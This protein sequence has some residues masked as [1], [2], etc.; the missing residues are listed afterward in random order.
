MREFKVE[1][2]KL[3][4][5]RR[6]IRGV[7]RKVVLP[8]ASAEAQESNLS[9]LEVII[10]PDCGVVYVVAGGILLQK[11]AAE[12]MLVNRSNHGVKSNQEVHFDFCL[13]TN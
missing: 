10:E 11:R 5:M 3:H 7:L 2:G 6:P 13:L 1:D 4:G 9:S 12:E 8:W